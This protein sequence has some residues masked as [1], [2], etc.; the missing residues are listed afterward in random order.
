MIAR[1]AGNAWL[2]VKQGH[3]LGQRI[4]LLRHLAL[5][6]IIVGPSHVTGGSGE[7]LGDEPGPDLG[8]LPSPPPKPTGRVTLRVVPALEAGALGWEYL[9][10]EA[11]R[12]GG[13]SC[14][15]IPTHPAQIQSLSKRTNFG[16]WWRA[17]VLA[18]PD[19]AAVSVEGRAPVPTRPGGLP[20]GMR[21]AV[22][23]VLHPGASL[24]AYD[25]QGRPDHRARVPDPAKAPSVRRPLRCP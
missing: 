4:D 8:A 13:G 18:A 14:C 20:Y 23:D 7:P 15:S 5:G 10:S 1:R 9:E 22:V 25:A 11:H 3:S 24:V 19:V 17:S 12:G 16:R 21:F 2:I 6:R